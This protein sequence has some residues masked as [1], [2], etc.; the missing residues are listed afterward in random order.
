MGL[1]E[2]VVCVVFISVV[3][4]L[5]GTYLKGRRRATTKS[6]IKRIEAL[7]NRMADDSIESRLQ[8]LE[9]IVTDNKHTLK[10]KIDAL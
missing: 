4:G 6:I 2:M 7:E 9:A 1:W 5:I 10:E 8:T 3:G